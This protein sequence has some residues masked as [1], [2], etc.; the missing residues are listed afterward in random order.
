[1]TPSRL[2][3]AR[4]KFAVCTSWSRGLP[5]GPRLGNR[6]RHDA[7]MFQYQVYSV[8][9][10]DLLL[11]RLVWLAQMLSLSY[12][13]VKTVRF[14]LDDDGHEPNGIRFKLDNNQRGII[15][16]GFRSKHGFNYGKLVHRC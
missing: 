8:R 5:G 2:T 9:R 15:G 3:A 10:G 12:R 14:T 6:P 7:K 1:M 16:P 13:C 4:T 11:L